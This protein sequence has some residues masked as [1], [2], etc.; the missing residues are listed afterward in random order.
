METPIGL[1]N[2]AMPVADLGAV[3][4]GGERR[5]VDEA[6]QS[7]RVGGHVRRC[8]GR[9]ERGPTAPA[10]KGETHAHVAGNG[11]DD[12]HA[13]PR[14]ASPDRAGTALAIRPAPSPTVSRTPLPR[15]L[16]A[17]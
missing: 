5:S 4:A 9:L 7:V 12:H 3:R 15:E 16:A 17:N 10:A 8:R 6:Q 2:D 13:T 1:V 14:H 11:V